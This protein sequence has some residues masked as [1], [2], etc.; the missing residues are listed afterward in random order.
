MTVALLPG[1]LGLDGFAVLTAAEVDGELELL[2]E[3]TADLVPC[4]ACGAVARPKDRA[5]AGC[6]TCPSPADRWSCAGGSR[7]VLPAPAV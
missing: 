6:A 1:L 2:I 3:T 7:V 4:P 5:R